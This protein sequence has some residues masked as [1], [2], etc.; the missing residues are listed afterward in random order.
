MREDLS[1]GQLMMVYQH[2]ERMDGKGYPVQSVDDEIHE[3]A[4]ICAVADVFHALTSKQPYRKASPITE[5]LGFIE[6][7]SGTHFGAE[8]VECWVRLMTP[9][10]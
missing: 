4:R 3:W 6:E 5:A 1:W 7:Q 9:R 10:S 8:I 2:H